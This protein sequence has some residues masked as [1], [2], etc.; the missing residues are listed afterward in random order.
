MAISLIDRLT[1]AWA[2]RPDAIVKMAESVCT[3]GF[4][5]K[6]ALTTTLVGTVPENTGTDT[7]PFA[8]VVKVTGS[9]LPTVP[10]EAFAV[11][12]TCVLSVNTTS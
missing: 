6:A 8:S 2:A 5:T 9:V 12:A 1:R 7:L 3:S 11:P 4:D 10:M